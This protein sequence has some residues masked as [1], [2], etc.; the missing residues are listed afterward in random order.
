MSSFHRVDS[1]H[2]G[3]RAA[4]RAAGYGWI[5]TYRQGDGCP[6]AFVLSRGGR[7]LALEIKSHGGKLTDAELHLWTSLPANAPW[8]MVESF[9]D[10]ERILEAIDD[11]GFV[12]SSSYGSVVGG[13]DGADVSCLREVSDDRA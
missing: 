7:W 13:A 8:A 1:V 3:I 12:K 11:E 6:D 2:A 4:A 9:S 5:D 10:L